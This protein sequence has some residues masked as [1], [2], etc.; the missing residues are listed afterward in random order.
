MYWVYRSLGTLRVPV[1]RNLFA[2]YSRSYYSVNDE[3][4]RATTILSI[5]K[6]DKVI[7][8]GDGQVSRGSSIVK[9]NAKKVRR[10]DKGKVITGFAGSTADA[11]TILERLE[12][13][14]EEF[15]GQLRRACV[16]VAQD[17]RTNRAYSNL[18][19]VM[20]VA[21]KNETYLL[22]GNGDVLE[23]PSHGIIAIGSGGD[24]A[25]SAAIA[26]LETDWEPERI[27]NKVC[28]FIIF[29]MLFFI[30]YVYVYFLILFRL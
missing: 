26:L 16:A 14:L 1:S 20:I 9:P 15:P 23:P 24:F 12:A 5:R 18:D 3:Q 4:W 28:C 19:A 2:S 7:V 6:N 21:D 8:I 29:I 27:A 22:S 11:V 25:A 10:L 17:W 30:K 13:K